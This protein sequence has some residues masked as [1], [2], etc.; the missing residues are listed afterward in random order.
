MSVL[1]CTRPDGLALASS[2][3]SPLTMLT[4]GHRA[5]EFPAPDISIDTL[6]A[7]LL[8]GLAGWLV[9]SHARVLDVCVVAVRAGAWPS[10][11]RVEFSFAHCTWLDCV[12]CDRGRR[13]VGGAPWRE[14]CVPD[15]V[16][17]LADERSLLSLALPSRRLHIRAARAT[18]L[19]VH[20]ENGLEF[21]ATFFNFSIFQPT[22]LIVMM[23]GRWWHALLAAV[24]ATAVATDGHAASETAIV[25]AVGDECTLT[26]AVPAEGEC[27]CDCVIVSMCVC[28]VIDQAARSSSSL[29]LDQ[30]SDGPTTPGMEYMSVNVHEPV[31]ASTGMHGPISMARS[32]TLLD[33]RTFAT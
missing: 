5:G 7:S 13:S 11:K 28:S 27:N 15:G 10:S 9:I 8:T 31:K 33:A 20:T 29:C 30:W 19:N 23:L 4:L 1:E 12:V 16:V 21:C 6:V 2:H 24:A 14:S 3:S 32:V 18:A 22:T 26:V 17:Q 25:A